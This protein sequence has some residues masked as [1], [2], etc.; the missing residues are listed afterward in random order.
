MAWSSLKNEEIAYF[1]Q[2]AKVCCMEAHPVWHFQP[3]TVRPLNLIKLEYGADRTDGRLNLTASTF[4]QL[5]QYTSR[6]GCR[7]YHYAELSFLPLQCLQP[8]PVLIA[9]THG[10][11]A[12]LSWPGWLVTQQDGSS[13][14]A[15]TNQTQ[16]RATSLIETNALRPCQIRQLSLWRLLLLN[17]RML[18]SRTYEK[19][20]IT[21]CGHRK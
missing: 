4:N 8:S 11:M 12:R 5:G 7:G 1:A 21:Y 19:H 17:L 10:G 16:H 18:L 13:V 3:A 2:T 15:N 6:P 14:H 20:G 9:P